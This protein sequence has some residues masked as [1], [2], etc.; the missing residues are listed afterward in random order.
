MGV[1]HCM[2]HSKFSEVKAVTYPLVAFEEAGSHLGV[3]VLPPVMTGAFVHHDVFKVGVTAAQP[4][5]EIL[6]MAGKFAPQRC[7][8]ADGEVAVAHGIGYVPDLLKY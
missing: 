6:P 5:G 4:G 7:V 3:P 8:E 2:C 1:Q